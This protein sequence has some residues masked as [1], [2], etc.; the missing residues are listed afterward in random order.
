MWGFPFSIG[1]ET[2]HGCNLHCPECFLGAGSDTLQESIDISLY[3]QLIEQTRPFLMNLSLYF[4]GEPSLNPEIMELI[5]MASKNRI[6]T[7]LSTNGNYSI[8]AFPEKVSEAGLDEIIFSMDGTTQESYST[9]RKGGSLKRIESN[10]EN[11]SAY[12][13]E[14]GKGPRVTVQF[15]VMRHNEGQVADIKAW[16]KEHRCRLKL[17]SLQLDD[18]TH[19]HVLPKDKKY[20][21]YEISS[22]KKAKIKNPLKNHCRR[23]WQNPVMTHR[24]DILPC[25][26]DKAANYVMGN[27]EGTDF[28]TIWNSYPYRVFRKRVLKERKKIDICTNCT[29]GTTHVYV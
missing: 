26:F 5:S 15:I 12:M 28:K 22:D 13:K 1:V 23:L 2:H 4:Q 7:V 27:I 20:R 3:Q 9:Y 14:T 8:E 21:R 24:G 29:E 18:I 6:H 17:K 25:C 16:A 11:L 19:T 10:I